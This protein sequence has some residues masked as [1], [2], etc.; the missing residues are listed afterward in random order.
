MRSCLFRQAG[1]RGGARCERIGPANRS[2][3]QA[4]GGG[5]GG[6]GP[7]WRRAAEHASGVQRQPSRRWDWAGNEF[8]VLLVINCLGFGREGT[9]DGNSVGI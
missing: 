5:P 1:R 6:L 8:V 7:R 4:G 9:G 3:E 2:L